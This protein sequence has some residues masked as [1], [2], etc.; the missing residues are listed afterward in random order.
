[1]VKKPGQSV[2]G[3]KTGRPIMV[4]FDLLGQ[5]WVLRILWELQDRQLSFR[6]LQNQCGGISPTSL[7]NRLKNLREL[8]LVEHTG[9]GYYLTA[10]GKKLGTRLLD[11]SRW[12][13]EWAKEL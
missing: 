5:R 13:D 1:M 11:L 4:L 2:K 9:E 12:A 7:N 8:Q 3:S 6:D 10:Q